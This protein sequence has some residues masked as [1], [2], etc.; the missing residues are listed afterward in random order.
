MFDFISRS[1]KISG[2]YRKKLITGMVM[3]FVQNLSLIMSFSAIYF[4]FYYLDDVSAGSIGLVV[5]ILGAGFLFNFLCNW[6]QNKFIAGVFFSIYKDYRLDVG[7]RLKKAR[8]GYFS[9]QSLSNILSCFTNIL[10]NLENLSQL[11][12][13]F[14]ISG[15][16]LSF[17]LLLGLFSMNVKIGALSLIL[18]AIAWSFVFLMFKTGKKYIREEHQ[19]TAL[20]SD[21]LIDGLRGIPVL[22]SFPHVK[23]SEIK[24]IHSAVYKT[25][26]DIE[27]KQTD[28]EVKFTIYSKIFGTILHAS[29][30][31]TTL[32]A[33]YLFTQN[34]VTMPQA[35]TLSA[36]S[37]ML[38]GGLKQLDASSLLLV[39]NP[40]HLDYLNEIMDIPNI[41]N[42]E[43]FSIDGVKNIE[44]EHVKF[45]YTGDKT[46]IND[47]SF[48]IAEGSK[49]AIVGPSGSGKTTLINLMA[50]FYDV[51]SGVIKIGG[52]NI[53]DYNVDALLKN[54]SLVFQ[55]VYLFSDT[56]KN[57]IKFAKPDAT[58]EEIIEVS[59]KAMCHDFIMKMKDGYD[60]VIGEGGSNISG[61]EKQR[62]SIARAL[63]K[64]A[65]IVLLDEAT[66]SVDPENEYEILKAI[67]V[68]CKGKT[69]IS[70]AH[71]LSTV[72]HADQIL[73]INEGILAQRGTHDELM[74]EEGIYSD[75][76]K[77]RENAKSWTLA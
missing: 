9:E 39:K 3:V 47:M 34:E 67:D 65:P 40:A 5:G 54:L 21:A 48:K 55:D 44:F 68:L 45:G 7:E 59:K 29:S 73:T 76:I 14:T 35:L 28:I 22:R 66:S 16:S 33:C 57:N 41:E 56:V 1:I 42:G 13:T 12:F 10:R 31:I 17:F 18:V 74:K 71:R 46:V 11:T 2:K 70:I 60:T 32:Y 43:I 69:V 8:M 36:A 38:F 51:D 49:T 4:A 6:L 20:F 77:A 23:E 63:L 64:D 50:R 15:M 25:A 72:K 24:E 52:Q 75:F 62:I 27:K 53:K 61:G 19:A 30:L 26:H 58:D 37:F